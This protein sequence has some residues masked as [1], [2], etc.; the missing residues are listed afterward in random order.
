VGADEIKTTKETYVDAMTRFAARELRH[1]TAAG[2]A[3][4]SAGDAGMQF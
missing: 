2:V 1:A 3:V 4:A